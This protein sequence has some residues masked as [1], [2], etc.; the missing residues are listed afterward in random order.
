MP[1]AH[2]GLT[3]TS[4]AHLAAR[5]RA[6]TR[7]GAS[8]EPRPAKMNAQAELA[9]LRRRID[10]LA[11]E[12]DAGRREITALR[13]ENARLRAAAAYPPGV[14]A[15]ATPPAAAPAPGFA[16]AAAP[17]VA[18]PAGYPA[19]PPGAAFISPKHALRRPEGSARSSVGASRR[20]RGIVRRRVATAPRDRPSTRRDAAAGSSTHRDAAA[21]SSVGAS[22]WRRG[23][24]RR[25]VAA[26]PRDRPSTR[27][28]R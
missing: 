26:A 7:F 11:A 27:V 25:R 1:E 19:P 2:S 14:Y 3:L 28:N 21:G 20:R 16:P 13:A 24:V 18:Y 22:R 5:F 9:L 23:I 10:V 4:R 6:P 8:L 15:V 17:G 12:A